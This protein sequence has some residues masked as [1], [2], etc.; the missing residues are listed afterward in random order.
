MLAM[1]GRTITHFSTW[2][3]RKYAVFCHLELKKNKEHNSVR[4][5]TKKASKQL[6]GAMGE[7]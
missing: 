5:Y 1:A 6:P 2:C 7:Q 3:I 4:Y